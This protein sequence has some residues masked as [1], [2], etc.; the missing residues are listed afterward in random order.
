MY[1]MNTMNG[2]RG[3]GN[4]RG[5]RNCQCGMRDCNSIPAPCSCGN[6][7]DTDNSCGMS[8]VER[9]RQCQKDSADTG[10]TDP[11]YGMPLAIGYVPWQQWNKIYDPAQGLANGTIFPELNL[12]FYGCIPQGCAKGGRI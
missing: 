2:C 4:C 3:N 5:N 10:C 8:S 7:P 9:N 11:L 1:V 6:A 12:Q